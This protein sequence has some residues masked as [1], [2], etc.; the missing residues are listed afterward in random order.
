MCF[1]YAGFIGSK[2]ETNVDDCV[3]HSC[4]NQATCVDGIQQ[5]TCRCTPQWTGKKELEQVA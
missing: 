4:A 5:Y 1:Y 3:R 2:C